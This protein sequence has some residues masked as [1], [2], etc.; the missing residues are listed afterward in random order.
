MDNFDLEQRDNDQL[1]QSSTLPMPVLFL[2][3]GSPMNAIIENEFTISWKKL[4]KS[5]IKPKAILCISAHWITQKG[6]AVTAM[7]KP[8]TIHDFGG[9]PQA[10]FDLQYPAEGSKKL[11]KEVISSIRITKVQADFS[12]GLDHGTWSILHHM[13]PEADIPVV[14]LSL[15]Y[16]QTA[17]FHYQLGQ[18]LRKLR[19]QGV[20]IMASGNMIH[21]L[22]LIAWE[23]RHLNE[24]GYDWAIEANEK[25]KVALVEKK[26]RVLLD[27]QNQGTAFE[28][29]IPTPDHY[30]PMLYVLGI[31]EPQDQLTIFNDRLVG[32]SLGMTSF[33][34]DFQT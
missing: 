11:A 25:M 7:Q 28:N 18:E 15:D 22:H 10:L 23:K 5:L 3:H 31:Q 16:G 19:R 21:N 9:F 33:R 13:Y 34:L 32:G 29:A 1:S 6:T 20:L 17:L 30:Y 27:W 26:H 2:G 12:W 24:Y 8:R 14:Q 4:G